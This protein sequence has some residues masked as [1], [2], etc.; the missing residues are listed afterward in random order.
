M[1]VDSQLGHRWGLV[2][3]AVPRLRLVGHK[4]NKSSSRQPYD[5]IQRSQTL[6]SLD[7]A[8]SAVL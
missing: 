1:T 8:W 4:V 2:Y 6:S 3:I 7:A 5:R